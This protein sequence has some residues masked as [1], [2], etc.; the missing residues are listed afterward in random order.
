MNIRIDDPLWLFLLGL[1]V[2]CAVVGLLWLGVMSV[3]RRWSA[4]LLRASFLILVALAL[5]GLATS[6]RVDR[7]ATIAVVDVSGSVRRFASAGAATDAGADVIDAARNAL[8]NASRGQQRE[9]DDLFGLVAFDGRAHTIAAP[10]RGDWSLRAL[11][12]PGGEGTDIA[13]ALQLAA[14]MV[15]PDAVG[16]LVLV[17]DG[18]QTA[19]NA[20]ETVSALNAAMAA[21]GPRLP[22]D[23]IPVEYDL[24]GEVMVESLDAPPRAPE[25]SRVSLRATLI[26]SAPVEG[27]LKV[28]DNDVPL[29][30]DGQP[31]GQGRRLSLEAG[32]RV[33]VIDVELSA[34][35]THRFRVVFEPDEGAGVAAS[36]RFSE[37]N[38][39]EAFTFSPGRGSVLLVDGT[40]DAPGGAGTSASPLAQVFERGGMNVQVV[41]PAGVPAD[42]LSF[43]PFDVVLLDNVP[44]DA[45]PEGAPETLA[46]FVREM[47]GG[48]V[49]IG[50]PASFGAGGWKGT[51]IEPLLPVRLD[52]PERL[53]IPE[54]AIAFVLDCS[55]SMRR[56]VMGSARSQQQIANESAALALGA[57]DK[58]DLVSVIRFDDR[59]ELVV[60]IRPNDDSVEIA[61]AIRRIQPDGGTDAL[62]GLEL[63]EA[64]LQD[65]EA[66]LKH[67]IVLS[68]GRSKNA[69]LLPDFCAR[70]AEK[71]IKV[72]TISVGD[73]ADLAT[74]DAM[75][76]RG[77][78]VSH[79]VSNPNIL[80]RVFAKAVRVVRT[81]MVREEPFEPVILDSGSPLT[82]GLPTPPILEGLTLTQPRAE[83]TVIN[84]MATPQG[85]PLLAHWTA[86]LGQVVAFTSDARRW[87]SQWLDWPGYERFWLAVVR[88]VSRSAGPRGVA[89]TA[90]VRDGRLVIRADDPQG[91]EVQR[92]LQ[93]PASV[94]A[95]DGGRQDVTLEQVAPGRYEASL[96]LERTG[97]FI[98]IVKPAD[99]GR[100]LPP[101]VVGATAG[102]AEEFRRF[103]SDPALLASIAGVS[104]GRVIPLSQLSSA[105]LFERGDVVP[106]YAVSGLWRGLLMA[107]I[108]VLLL[109]I[110]TR[111]IAWD[112][113]LREEV[114]VPARTPSPGVAALRR[115][116]SSPESGFALSEQD[117]A[118]LRAAAKDRRRAERLSHQS[119]S[120]A[121]TASGEEKPNKPSEDASGLLAAKRRAAQRFEEGNDTG[122]DG[123][124]A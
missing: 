5:A 23:V 48:L 52:L 34:S 91:S 71:G 107:A 25:S 119:P 68:D 63:A 85:E 53:M 122:E 24:T 102:Q 73:Q 106:R 87:A 3:A 70:L 113:L 77:G 64:Q 104:G 76:Q 115:P 117:A 35:R 29:A 43:E 98:A 58:R 89:A 121:S 10:G 9:P 47:G 11:E 120:T 111:R 57:L 65:V 31:A 54:V 1:I 26:A 94:Y 108:G 45:L 95:P 6:T 116:A 22:V 4:L 21:G 30:V 56:G 51:P 66:K 81:P 109:D 84:A 97:T 86:E 101:A 82:A 42:L 72:S 28:F 80:P 27:V 55:G 88:Q 36:D 59:A 67:V 92:V 50:G 112:R 124:T 100:R 79:N 96:P 99:G 32:R 61:T 40:S 49:M 33:E 7:L 105:N 78:G 44:A 19:G 46:S 90:E 14:A 15:P 118:R 8:L 93:M 18:N 41:A 12:P 62:T 20:V 110:A 123:R 83:P 17:S 39:A 2:P 69:D 75:A 103:R 38:S 114:A 13:S 60:P 16:R 74:M 37:N